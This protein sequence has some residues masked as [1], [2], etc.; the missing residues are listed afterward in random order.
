MPLVQINTGRYCYCCC[1]CCCCCGC[2][3]ACCSCRC[4]S[5]GCGAL[6][7]I[8]SRSTCNGTRLSRALCC[9]RVNQDCILVLLL[10]PRQWSTVAG[11]ARE[12]VGRTTWATG[13]VRLCLPGHTSSGHNSRGRTGCVVWLCLPCCKPRAQLAVLVWP[14]IKLSH[15][16]RATGCVTRVC[17]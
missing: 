8:A 13:C 5:W 10:W 16:R 12:S 15:I 3:D 14:P 1:G 11:P 2:D 7:A 6:A 17:A 4:C 9:P